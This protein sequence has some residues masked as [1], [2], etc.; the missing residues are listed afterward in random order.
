MPSRTIKK[1]KM[2]FDRLAAAV[3]L[4]AIII[5]LLYLFI[6]LLTT[7]SGKTEKPVASTEKP[8]SAVSTSTHLEF[9]KSS[10]SS[11]LI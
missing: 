2:R 7:P 6:Q 10:I 9:D 11:Y 8:D 1:R 5:F 4:L 3:F